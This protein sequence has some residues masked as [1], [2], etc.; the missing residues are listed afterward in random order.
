MISMAKDEETIEENEETTE[1][2]V[3]EELLE[4]W[5]EVLSFLQKIVLHPVYATFIVTLVGIAIVVSLL[6]FTGIDIRDFL[7]G[8]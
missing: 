2:T 8:K 4:W 1:E 5:R 7:L 3:E 6:L